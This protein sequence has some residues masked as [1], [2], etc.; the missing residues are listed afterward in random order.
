[1][2]VETGAAGTGV[3]ETGAAETEGVRTA[4]P[5]GGEG[6]G[7]S[8]TPVAPGDLAAYSFVHDVRVAADGTRAF[9]ELTSVD[10]PENRYLTDIWCVDAATGEV[11]RLT[12]SGT[13]G[14]YEPM[15]DGSVVFASGRLRAEAG[16]PKAEPGCDLFRIDPSGGEA[17]LLVRLRGLAASDWRQLDAQRLVVRC[18]PVFDEDAPAVV[19]EDAPFYENGGTYTSGLR[20]GLYLLDLSAL[21]PDRAAGPAV[22][23]PAADASGALRLLTDADEEVG[24]WTLAGASSAGTPSAGASGGVAPGDAAPARTVAFASKHFAGLR[25]VA[26]ELWVLDVATGV[27]R[28]IDGA[29]PDGAGV[30]IEGIEAYRGGLLCLVNDMRAHGVNQDPQ[31]RLV[32]LDGAWADPFPCPDLCYG[33]AMSCDSSYGGGCASRVVG[34]SWYAVTTEFDGAYVRR[35]ELGDPDGGCIACERVVELDGPVVSFDTAD[36]RTFWCVAGSP[37]G[38]PEVYRVELGVAAGSEAPVREAPARVVRVTDC[39]R[40]LE[41]RLVSPPEPFEFESNGA[42][43]TGYVIKP[44]GYDG[45][46]DGGAPAGGSAARRAYPAVLEIHGGPKVAYGTQFSHEMQVLAAQGY[47]VLFTNPHGSAGRGGDFADIRGRYGREDYADLMAFVD[48]ALRRYPAIDPERLAVMGGSYGGFM[49]NWIVGHTNRFR[50]ANSQ[51]SIANYMTKFLVSDIGTWVNMP[52]ITADPD[53]LAFEGDN[54]AKAWEQ[55]PLA[56]AANVET[57]TL[58]LHSDRDYRCPLEEG[59]Q[60]YTALVLRGVPARLVVFKGEHHGL[61]RTGKPQNRVRRIEEI[62]AWYRHWLS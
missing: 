14:H 58:F 6:R 11:R 34:G 26:D 54:P 38:L 43:L 22:G 33:N 59:M 36:G 20:W 5:A 44:V 3:A 23:V 51:R 9:Y 40:A 49:T 48:E 1:M 37:T 25:P 45:A 8:A 60:M 18:R 46:P 13:E 55:S 12:S 4:A 28:R 39:S 50:C 53:A 31:P 15:G 42:T 62:V 57:P 16:G 30:R 41:G 17:E 56:F 29:C 35:I 47:F 10:M 7:L 27:R 52:E 2:A 24:A 21:G 19:I 61:S 32:S